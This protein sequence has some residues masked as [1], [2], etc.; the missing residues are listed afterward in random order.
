MKIQLISLLLSSLF[1]SFAIARTIHSKVFIKK[2]TQDTV[3]DAAASAAPLPPTPQGSIRLGGDILIPDASSE[4]PLILSNAK[5]QPLCLPSETIKPVRDLKV[6]PGYEFFVLTNKI[7]YPKKIV[8]DKANHL[9]AISSKNG[10]YS[11]RMDKCGN[12]EVQQILEHDALGEPLGMGME[13]YGQHLYISTTHSIYRF[14]YSDGQH[15]ALSDGIKVMS[16][17]NS[18]N[19][20]ITDIAIDVFGYAFIPRTVSQMHQNLD[21]SHA[22]IKKFNFKNIPDSAYDFERDGEVFASGTNTQGLLGFDAQAQLWGIN[23]L[24]EDASLGRGNSFIRKYKQRLTFSIDL[25]LAGF[26]EELNKYSAPQKNYGFPYCLTEHNLQGISE[27]S[28]GL[29]AQWAHALFVNQSVSLNDYCQQSDNN[30]PPEVPLAPKTY[31]SS[32]HFYTG[33]FCS[34]GDLT[35]EGTS[36]GLPC[37]WTNTPILANHGQPRDPTGHSVVHLPFNDLEHKPRLDLAAEVLLQETEPCFD[38]KCF[39]PFGL[40]LDNYGRL[41]ISSDETNEIIVF[42]RIFNEKAAETLTDIVEKAEDAKYE[43]EERRK[44][45]ES[46]GEETRKESGDDEE[47]K[48]KDSGDE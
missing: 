34:V 45:K 22:V 14:P 46:D 48:H 11:I 29:G 7:E 2:K 41:Y 13:L 25:S 20:E 21:A 23:G 19:S 33:V 40:A 38:D 31:A 17:M 8:M 37:N 27:V 18:D 39:S 12:S 3:D 9:L 32:A 26:A 28:R 44:E 24:L 36:V 10:V 35:T 42:K 5:D 6:M 1:F 16:N 43:E 15:S 4:H 30:V 47:Q